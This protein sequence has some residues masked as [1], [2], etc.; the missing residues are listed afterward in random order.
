MQTARLPI[1]HEKIGK[2]VGELK[3]D[4]EFRFPHS[5]G[6]VVV[7]EAINPHLAPLSILVGEVVMGEDGPGFLRLGELALEK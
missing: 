2:L 5:M 3:A 6:G 1:A 7:C 4:L